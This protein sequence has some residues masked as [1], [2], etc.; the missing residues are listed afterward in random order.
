M[1]CRCL[2]FAKLSQLDVCKPTR[3]PPYCLLIVT[4]GNGRENGIH[5]RYSIVNYNFN[6]T[7]IH[8][9]SYSFVQAGNISLKINALIYVLIVSRL[10]KWP[11]FLCPWKLRTFSQWIEWKIPI[12]MQ[13]RK[14][15]ILLS[16]IVIIW[17]HVNTHDNYSS[18]PVSWDSGFAQQFRWV[19]D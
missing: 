9:S 13:S 1:A 12:S 2:F 16:M 6:L 4:T 3:L 7:V 17:G 14:F 11:P 10:S 19:K 15:N 8:C 5:C 18:R